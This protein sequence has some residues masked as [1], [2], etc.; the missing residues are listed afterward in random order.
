MCKIYGTEVE[1]KWYQHRSEVVMENDK[2][3][4]LWDFTV[5]VDLEIYRR[6]PDLIVVQKDK[7][8]CQ[9]I[10]F[11]CPY[12]GRVNRIE[13]EKKIEHYQYLARELRKI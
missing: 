4:I 9:V 1:E 8:L 7:N 3:K 2:H 11:V 13:L 10:D 6:R 12:N 5:Q